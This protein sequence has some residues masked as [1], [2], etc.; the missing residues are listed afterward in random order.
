MR[1]I[2]QTYEG[3]IDLER[4]V[5][6]DFLEEKDEVVNE[7]GQIYI[8]AC[9]AEIENYYRIKVVSEEIS[10]YEY[11][12]R[13]TAKAHYFVIDSSVLLDNKF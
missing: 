8:Y 12:E 9:Q 3:T 7:L 13:K 2:T 1:G 4:I 5:S 10:L 11:F 6:L